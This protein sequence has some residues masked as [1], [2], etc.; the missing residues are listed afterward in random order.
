MT[1]DK[2]ATFWK[3]KK[4]AWFSHQI[5][6]VFVHGNVFKDRSRNSAKFKMELFAATGNGRTYNQWTA[7]YACCC[8]NHFY[9][10]IIKVRWKW[11]CLEGGASDT[12][13]CFINMFLHFFENAN[14]ITPITFSLTFCFIWKINY[15]NGN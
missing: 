11:P 9:R 14:F 1:V 10:Y 6:L 7:V 5:G 12:I 2:V 4:K 3:N 13:S 15:K 8:D